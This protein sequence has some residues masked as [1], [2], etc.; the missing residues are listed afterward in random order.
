MT[1]EEKREAR[2]A[3]TRRGFRDTFGMRISVRVNPLSSCQVESVFV[4]LN[5]QEKP[6]FFLAE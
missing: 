6:C 3:E 5:M 4:D 1:N 2:S